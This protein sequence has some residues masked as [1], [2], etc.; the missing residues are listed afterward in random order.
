VQERGPD[1]NF[2]AIVVKILG[3]GTHDHPPAGAIASTSPPA[4]GFVSVRR[5]SLGTVVFALV[6]LLALA[7]AGAAFWTAREVMAH[8]ADRAEIEYLR[9]QL[10]SL[11]L[12]VNQ[13][14][15]PFGPA[16]PPSTAPAATQP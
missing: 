6:A 9:T 15:Q 12:R 1:D 11:R 5:R 8:S 14:E 4:R 7:A 10:D 2:T 13:L 16:L 3:Q